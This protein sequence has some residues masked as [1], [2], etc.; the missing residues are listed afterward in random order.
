[1]MEKLN[2][3]RAELEEILRKLQLL[4]DQLEDRTKEKNRL[5]DNIDL[6]AQKLI[7]AEQLINGLSGEKDRWSE[8]AKELQSTLDNAIGDI[9][10]AS[11]VIAYL[12]A[13]TVDYRNVRISY[14]L[15]LLILIKVFLNKKKLGTY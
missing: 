7:R 6:C 14:N 1:M 3:K 11:G 9:L 10:L 12:G 8:A 2:A 15:F 13:F 5:Q 4:L